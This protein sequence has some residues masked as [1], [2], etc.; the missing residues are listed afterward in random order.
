MNKTAFTTATITDRKLYKNAG[1]CRLILSFPGISKLAKPGQFIMLK[2]TEDDF[3]LPFSIASCRGS[4]MSIYVKIVG[5]GTRKLS[6]LK[7]DTELQCLAP[8]G[9]D[10]GSMIYSKKPSEIIM[11]SGG[12]GFPP[13]LSFLN[14]NFKHGY[15]FNFFYG[16]RKDTDLVELKFKRE[17]DKYIAS[18]DGSIG[19]KGT[20]I[21]LIKSRYKDT[22]IENAIVLACGNFKML[23]ALYNEFIK[24][25]ALQCFVSME[26]RMACGMGVCQGCVIKTNNE[27]IPYLRV[28]KD[29][30]VFN[31]DI[32]DWDCNPMR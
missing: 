32:I 30:P 19:Y 18:E 3:M 23:K 22:K 13:L 9:N 10:F 25:H 28:C 27:K 4:L 15:K 6:R 17:V 14:K 26:T 31:A 21:D 16:V 2:V 11:V 7:V 29:G 12:I 20:V 5:E 24:V 1:I 8:L